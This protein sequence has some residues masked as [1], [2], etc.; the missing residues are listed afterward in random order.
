VELIVVIAI[1]ALLAL[2]S[3]NAYLSFTAARRAN[4]GAQ[5]L[6]N[7][8]SAA[9]SQ[10]VA[11]QAPYRVVIQ[12]RDPAAGALK[13]AFW[14]DEMDPLI[15]TSNFYPTAAQ[16]ALGVKRQQVHGVVKPPEGV[17]VTDVVA[18]T[19]STATMPGDPAYAVVF[20]SP[21]GSASYASVRLEDTRARDAAT[22]TNIVKVYPATGRAIVVGGTP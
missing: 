8:L 3:V 9:R 13:P 5:M 19:T 2:L 12:R 15:P 16:L 14:I 21:S 17:V 20:F 22:R 11:T 4:Y 7:V 18:G 6:V 10:A 1:I